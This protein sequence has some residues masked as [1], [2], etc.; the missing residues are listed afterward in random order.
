MFSSRSG[1][2]PDR[3][4]RSRP[5]KGRDHTR[6]LAVPPFFSA[7]SALWRHSKMQIPPQRDP[8]GAGRC[9][10]SAPTCRSAPSALTGAPDQTYRACKTFSL[11]VLGRVRGCCAAGLPPYPG[12]LEQEEASTTPLQHIFSFGCER[13][14]SNENC[15]CQA[16]LANSH[17][18]MSFLSFSG[19]KRHRLMRAAISQASTS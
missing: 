2:C 4:K 10:P 1:T 6:I 13:H 7:K 15:Q 18:F 5:Q 12:S 16:R 3:N 9:H 19:G 14:S 11:A 17:R 8:A